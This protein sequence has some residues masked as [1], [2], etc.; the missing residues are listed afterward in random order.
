MFGLK[1]ALSSCDRAGGTFVEVLTGFVGVTVVSCPDVECDLLAG[2]VS[3]HVLSIQGP[4]PTNTRT[5][6]RAHR[7]WTRRVTA[8]RL[9]LRVCV[10]ARLR[11]CMRAYCTLVSSLVVSGTFDQGGG[12]LNSPGFGSPTQGEGDRRVSPLLSSRAVPGA[13]PGFDQEGVTF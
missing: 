3:R 13:D 2:Q 9:E 5:H 12:F 8:E 7:S 6:T 11:G 4:L 1:P 10:C